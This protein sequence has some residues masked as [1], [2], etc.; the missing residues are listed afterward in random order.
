MDWLIHH[1]GILAAAAIG[2]A[3]VAMILSVVIDSRLRR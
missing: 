3:A 1:K 2:I